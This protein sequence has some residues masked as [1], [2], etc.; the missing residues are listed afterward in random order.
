MV[1]ETTHEAS[2]VS[3][4]G[5]MLFAVVADAQAP[6]AGRNGLAASLQREREIAINGDVR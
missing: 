1:K 3:R 5:L 4:G 6:A 2:D